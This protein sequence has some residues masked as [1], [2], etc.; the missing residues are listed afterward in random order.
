MERAREKETDKKLQ[1]RTGEKQTKKKNKRHFMKKEKQI[2]FTLMLVLGQVM[3]GQKDFGLRQ[4]FT[5]RGDFSII[6]NT[7]MRSRDPNEKINGPVVMYYVDVDGNNATK[8][9]SSANLQL[10]DNNNNN[11]SVDEC[12]KIK[13][14]RLYWFGRVDDCWN[15]NGEMEKRKKVK[16]KYGGG[17]YNDLTAKELYEIGG[18]TERVYV[19]YADVTD[20]VRENKSGS[21]TVANVE[22]MSSNDSGGGKRS[23]GQGTTYT[24]YFRKYKKQV[25]DSYQYYNGAYYETY[26]YTINNGQYCLNDYPGQTI[27]DFPPAIESECTLYDRGY[28]HTKANGTVIQDAYDLYS[29]QASNFEDEGCN[30]YGINVKSDNLGYFGGWTMVVVYENPKMEPKSVSLFDGLKLVRQNGGNVDVNIS[31]FST[32]MEGEID[33]RLGMTVI[34]GDNGLAGDKFQVAT[35]AGT[36]RDVQRV[37]SSRSD[38]FDGNIQGDA[39]R[40]PE[41][42]VSYGLDLAIVEGV[43]FPKPLDNAPE[44]KI[45]YNGQTDLKTRFVTSGDT[46]YPVVYASSVSNY[47]PEPVG[48]GSYVGE[49]TVELNPGDKAEFKIDVYNLGNEDIVGGKIFIPIPESVDFKLVSF[50]ATT[51][52]AEKVFGNIPPSDGMKER[53][54]PNGYIVWDIGR[55]IPVTNEKDPKPLATLDYI[56]Q[57]SKDC[58]KLR[59]L[60]SGE[61]I[62]VTVDGFMRGRGKY[63]K[64]FLKEPSIIAKKGVV[65]E[66]KCRKVVVPERDNAVKITRAESGENC[67]YSETKQPIETCVGNTYE[68]GFPTF[69][70]PYADNLNAGEKI[71]YDWSIWRVPKSGVLRVSTGGEKNRITGLQGKSSVSIGFGASGSWTE[72]YGK[73]KGFLNSVSTTIIAP[74]P[75]LGKDEEIYIKVDAKKIGSDGKEIAGCSNTEF[76]PISLMSQPAGDINSVIPPSPICAADGVI[77]VTSA[78]NKS[79]VLEEDPLTGR[80]INGTRYTLLYKIYKQ[81]I[82]EA[83]KEASPMLQAHFDGGGKAKIDLQRLAA[84]NY[85][86]APQWVTNGVCK[87]SVKKEFPFFTINAEVKRAKLVSD[88]KTFGITPVADPGIVTK[89]KLYKK[90]VVVDKVAKTEIVEYRRI[91]VVGESYQYLAEGSQEMADWDAKEGT[92]AVEKDA[93]GKIKEKKIYIPQLE[94]EYKVEAITEDTSNPQKCKGKE[95]GIIYVDKNKTF[96]YINPNLRIRVKQ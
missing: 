33:V 71:Q 2:L 11:I 37:G 65:E 50:T 51:G 34:E 55:D 17:I 41:L 23:Q 20:L 9:S 84:G 83:E 56:V 31:G 91:K 95:V 48:V 94:G 47:I 52:K 72:E 59:M 27:T 24:V 39:G 61:P 12:T 53:V 42:Q 26:Y 3:L 30:K 67:S 19:A 70:L 7:V 32:P 68:D 63:S 62:S 96:H 40:N 35:K 45:I 86:Y 89:Y 21:Y 13:Y 73:P 57:V 81:E 78:K 92:I 28:S 64:L 36:Y 38:T 85:I 25:D 49:E 66:S 75:A 88:G 69:N 76:T 82:S 90:V 79:T 93:T 10:I 60:C 43:N 77:D 46:Y 4:N 29:Y 1:H 44:S 87:I 6:G 80:V 8:N 74:V 15:V 22:T 5:L 18:P 14:A 54:V 58:E 16:I